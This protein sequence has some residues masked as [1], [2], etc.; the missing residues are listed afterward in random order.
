MGAHGCTD[1]I[2]ADVQHDQWLQSTVRE[3]SA[4]LFE[5]KATVDMKILE[6]SRLHLKVAGL[7]SLSSFCRH[8]AEMFREILIDD[9]YIRNLWSVL[10][11]EQVYSTDEVPHEMPEMKE[12]KMYTDPVPVLGSWSTVAASEQRYMMLK[13]LW[14][15]EDTRTKKEEKLY[16]AM[17][18]SGIFPPRIVFP[19]WMA[20]M[21]E[22][23]GIGT[24]ASAWR[25]KYKRVGLVHN[26]FAR[27]R[28][29]EIVS[30]STKGT[31][32]EIQNDAGDRPRGAQV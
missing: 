27:A 15:Y 21:L 19:G 20:E 32:K 25:H 4:Q 24:D 18:A 26:F 5:Y 8:F 2:N 17:T 30:P 11:A 9:V 22:Q 13:A 7:K 14:F 1:P 10:Y 6:Q 16:N 12:G 31:A 28:G 29:Q 3:A 23:Q